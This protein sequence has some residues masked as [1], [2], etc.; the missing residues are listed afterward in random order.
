MRTRCIARREWV[1]DS[2]VQKE[3]KDLET[4]VYLPVLDRYLTDI[5]SVIA[6]EEFKYQTASP[7]TIFF[8]T[9]LGTVINDVE[10]YFFSAM[11]YGSYTHMVITREILARVLYKY[12]ELTQ[13]R[14]LLLDCIKILVING[15][16]EQFNKTIDYK[17][18]DA[19]AEIVSHADE[20]WDLTDAAA[21]SH[22]ESIKQAVITKLGLYLTDS[23]FEE[24]HVFLEELAP[25][26]YWGTSQD[27]FES[28]N[29]NMCRLNCTRVM[30]ML[31]GIIKEQRFHLGGKL[32]NI[33]LQMKIDDVDTEVQS[34]F[35]DALKE[36]ISFIAKNGG[37][38]QIIAALAS[39]SPEIFSVLSTIPENGLTGVEKV[40]YDINMGAGNWGEV[41]THEIE[42]ARKQF[43][44]NRDPGTY[45]G[46]F[47]LPYAM[48]KKVIREHYASSMD[49][50]IEQKFFPLCSEVLTSQAV[51][52]VK[53]D[54]LDCLCDVL[55]FNTALKTKMPQELSD[56][57]AAIGVAKTGTILRHSKGAFVCRT[58]MV[59]IISGAADKEE[60]LEWCV[61]YGKKE[62]NER[63][64]LAECI[65]QFIVQ[66]LPAGQIDATILSIVMQCFD[67]EHYIVR[68]RACNCF[69]LLLDT[70]YRDLAERKL[71]E[72]AIDPSHYVRS[73]V[74]NLCK[75]KKI[76]APEICDELFGI[77]T[78]DANYAIR[79]GCK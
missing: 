16:A 39:Q 78:N 40:F 10:N 33:I 27:Y 41:L 77:L 15:D 6:K 3:L 58:L 7:N 67:D 42:I 2:D 48:I 1:I 51:A 30:L 26:V 71:C 35:C 73:Q 36:K 63:I 72:A 66:E 59:K 14:P 53:N 45:T 76:K 50:V 17:W 55:V 49:G 57:I 62:I 69:A 38:P 32:A 8:G 18:D 9:N 20:I 21:S 25:T 70:K 75:S 37:T 11:L 54:C 44:V 28:I 23:K 24:V 79:V 22:K 46:F 13:K 64:A 4:I 68:R 60:L 74:L 43:E 65:E 29:Q 31:T 56:A 34:S 5:Y 52:K 19:Y 47:E 12:D 61:G